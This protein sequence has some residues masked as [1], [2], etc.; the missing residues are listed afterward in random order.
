MR[1]PFGNKCRKKSID[2]ASWQASESDRIWI[3]YWLNSL[4]DLYC[5]RFD[6]R[7]SMETVFN[8]VNCNRNFDTDWD[9]EEVR[10]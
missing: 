4:F 6:T 5:C 7:K 2:E 3:D 1:V 10:V 8:S 9:D